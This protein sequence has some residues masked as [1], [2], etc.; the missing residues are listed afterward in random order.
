MDNLSTADVVEKIG[1]R[2]EKEP[3]PDYS[4]ARKT[5]IILASLAG[6]IILT[7]FVLKKLIPFISFSYL[8][9]IFTRSMFGLG[10]TSPGSLQ[11]YNFNLK[12]LIAL[13][14]AHQPQLQ[15]NGSSL[16][17]VTDPNSFL[18]IKLDDQ[19]MSWVGSL[20][21]FG[22]LLGALAGNFFI[23]LGLEP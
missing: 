23:N 22:A 11:L 7:H 16:V 20:I 5:P 14:F 4:T 8:G 13:L 6:K 12:I 19:Q 15:Q 9:C 17:S 18:Y 21:N 10:V 1:G 2:H 3:I